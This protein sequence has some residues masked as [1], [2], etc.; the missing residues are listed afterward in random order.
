MLDH[1]STSIP[2][3]WPTE[4]PSTETFYIKIWAKKVSMED[5]KILN[6]VFIPAIQ[7]LF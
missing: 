3:Y 2:E 4:S 6:K 5:K 7:H 1:K